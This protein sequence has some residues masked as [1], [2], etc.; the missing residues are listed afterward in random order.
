[1]IEPCIVARV[2][3]TTALAFGITGSA[4]IESPTPDQEARC[5]FSERNVRDAD[6]IREVPAGRSRTIWI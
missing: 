1:M 6:V 4:A 2:I 3:A 5:P